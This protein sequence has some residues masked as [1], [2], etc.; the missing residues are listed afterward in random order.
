METIITIVIFAIIYGG[1]QLYINTALDNY[2]MSKV[3]TV[4]LSSD[5]AK[6]VSVGE[7]RV[8][9]IKGYYDKK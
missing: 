7:R 8:R 6:G 4:K 2:D 9:C 1:I 5:A 3:D